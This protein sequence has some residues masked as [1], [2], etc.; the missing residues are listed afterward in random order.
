TTQKVLPEPAT[1]SNLRGRSYDAYQ[2]DSGSSLPSFIEIRERDSDITLS[3]CWPARAFLA[4]EALAGA[5][6]FAGAADLAGAA[7]VA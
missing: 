4:V 5:A 1:R 6:F 3:C 2:P 7:L